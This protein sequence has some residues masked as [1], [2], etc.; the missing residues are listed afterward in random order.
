MAPGQAPCGDNPSNGHLYSAK[1]LA[2]ES[3]AYTTCLSTLSMSHLPSQPRQVLPRASG[4]TSRTARR[5]CAS[6]FATIGSDKT[7]WTGY[8]T[9]NWPNIARVTVYGS[10]VYTLGSPLGSPAW[11]GVDSGLYCVFVCIGLFISLGAT[12]G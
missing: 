1:R 8:L 3:N 9:P 6:M 10:H 12:P 7:H 2:R 5:T 11:Q 4:V